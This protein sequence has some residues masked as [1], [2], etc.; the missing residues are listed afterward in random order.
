MVAGGGP[1]NRGTH[2]AEVSEIAGEASEV[3]ETPCWWEH[4]VAAL[5]LSHLHLPL[6]LG[7]GVG[8]ADDGVHLV[9]GGAGLQVEMLAG[10]SPT[11]HGRVGTPGVAEGESVVSAESHGARHGRGGAQHQAVEVN[12]DLTD[13]LG[14]GADGEG[15]GGGGGGGRLDQVGV[16]GGGGAAT[17]NLED[18]AHSEPLSTA[19]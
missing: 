18:T 5:Y 14:G 2:A 3:L 4:G 17:A 15:A 7:D 10:E 11:Q 8:A 12:P 19:P 16:V 6:S 9:T 13:L 1:V